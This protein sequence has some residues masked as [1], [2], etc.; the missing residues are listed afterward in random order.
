V[1]LLFALIRAVHFAA[2]MIVFGG[3]AYLAL[4]GKLRDVRPRDSRMRVLFGAAAATALL[5]SAFMLCLTAGQMSGDWRASYDPRQ[6]W[7]VITA[8]WY[9]HVSLI[10]LPVLACLFLLCAPARRPLAGANTVFAGAA[11]ALIGLTSHAAA[12]GA[13]SPLL[14]ANHALHLLCA[15]F[16]IGGLA[17]LALILHERKPG[18]RDALAVF[19]LWGTYA[20]FL[21]AAAGTINALAILRGPFATWSHTY[22][23]VLAIKIMLAAAMMSLALA[24]RFRLSPAI[25]A[26]ESDSA[27]ILRWSVQVELTLGAIIV[28]L[29]S[30]LGLLSPN[31]QM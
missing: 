31:V 18:L 3:S 28:F 30:L 23:T 22:L 14:A 1:T 27:I 4:I 17:V 5:T 26:G 8:T 15:G 10:R 13:G 29:A 19:S 24:N 25:R 11:L 2:L 21:L 16:W 6:V 20:V 9:G 12:S 7:A